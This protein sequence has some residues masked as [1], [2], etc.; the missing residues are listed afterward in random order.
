MP[1]SLNPVRIA[2]SMV[3]SLRRRRE[4]AARRRYTSLARRTVAQCGPGL[5]VNGPC[6]LTRNTYLGSNVNMNGLEINGPGKVQIGSNFH[7]GPGCLLI[8]QN[9]NYDNG[10]A[11]PYDTTAIVKEITIADN[12]WL[13]TRVIVLAGVTINEGAIIQA[14]SVVVSDVPRCAIAG[15]HPAHVFSHRDIE[16]YERLV[17]E[18]KFC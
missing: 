2:R 18:G 7:S 12:V 11:I 6:R 3:A 10:E 8:T 4:T 1:A 5:H 17:A 9:H 14:G 15:G 16:H 13:G